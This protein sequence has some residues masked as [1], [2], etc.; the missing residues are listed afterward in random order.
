MIQFDTDKPRISLQSTSNQLIMLR[1]KSRQNA[2]FVNMEVDVRLR[3]GLR[4]FRGKFPQVL[5]RFLPFPAC[6]TGLGSSKSS[7]LRR[8]SDPDLSSLKEVT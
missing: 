6:I 1:T 3:I 5:K 4:A 7:I 2:A 8:F